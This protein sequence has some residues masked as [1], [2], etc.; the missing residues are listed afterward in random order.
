M[1]VKG[2]QVRFF[3][4]GP[5]AV[6]AFSAHRKR[7]RIPSAG[8][9][10]SSAMLRWDQRL[11]R[12]PDHDRAWREATV[13]AGAE[14]HQL[15]TNLIVELAPKT[16]GHGVYYQAFLAD[17]LVY[18]DAEGTPHLAPP[19]ERPKGVT[20]ERGFSIDE[21]LECLA[22]Q[23]QN[24]LTRTHPGDSLFVMM[25]PNATRFTQP[26]LVDRQHRECVCLT[27]AALYD[28]TEQG[29]NLSTTAQ[30]LK[31]LLVDSHGLAL[32]KNPVSSVARLGD[33][34]V[35]TTIRLLQLPLPGP[36]GP[37]PPICHSTNM[38]L[39][40]WEAWLDRCTGTRREAGSLRLLLDGD[41]FFPRLQQA[42]ADATNHI[43][44][45]IYM[46]DRDDVGVSVADQLKQRSREV[47]VRVILDCLGSITAG[48]APPG[49]PMPE[50][51]VAPSA[52]TSYLRQNSQVR[53][54]QFLNPWLSADH[55]KVFLLDGTRA[56]LGGMNLGR[57]YRYE[58]H[59]AMVE[60]EGPVVAS[61]ED[62][63]R[64][65]WAHE[66]MLGDLAYAATLLSGP[67][68]AKAAPGTGPWIP[69]RLLP[70]KTAW[71]PYS[72]AVFG[73]L[74]QARNYIYAENPYLFDKRAISALARA[75]QR[76]VDVR[77]VFPRANDV[78]TRGRSNLVTANYLIEHGVRVFFYPGMT[79]VKALLVDDW[80]CLGSANLNH[81]S[82]RLCQEQ[83]VAT[84][85]PAFA[86]DLKRELFDEDF[87][88]SYELTHPVSVDWVDFLADQVLVDF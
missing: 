62:E 30:G 9:K 54:R 70:T 58:W 8:Y 79:H 23:V 27:P 33:L 38:D 34:A 36:R 1:F 11:S 37:A 72:T 71:K 82:L 80:A 84:S 18:R 25:A 19:G 78:G 83:N 73:A 24:R 42:I 81:L 48:M 52:I 77:V 28:T 10:V 47:K 64:R 57:E 39:T 32:V 29:L 75:R 6:E 20:I 55:Y 76:G 41:Q 88:R 61:L 69:L 63:F 46:F 53:V 12:L 50:D 35:Q 3:F 17:R 14:W 22:R 5:A 86:A 49:T 56:F 44:F 67:S 31:G 2:D 21:T 51:F 60:L 74:S 85:D 4:P 59:D 68:A 26:L 87:A 16:A 43:D 15:A 45:N 40:A 66:G 7:A 13:I 65:A